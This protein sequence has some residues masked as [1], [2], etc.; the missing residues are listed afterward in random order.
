MKLKNALTRDGARRLI[1]EG[2]LALSQ[3]EA[4]GMR[5]DTDQLQEQTEKIDRRIEKGKA[6]LQRSKMHGRMKRRFREF[7]LTSRT[8]LGKFLFDVEGIDHPTGEKTKG[9]DW[10]CDESVLSKIN[11]PYVKNFNRL[12]KLLKMR[13]VYLEGIHRQT[14]DGFIHPFFHLAFARTHRGTSQDPNFQN[15]PIRDPEMGKIIRSCFIPRDDHQIVEI[16]YSAIEVRVAACYH[17]DPKMLRYINDPSTDMH[18]D[19]AAD[20]FKCDPSQVSKTMRYCGKNMFVFPQFYGSFWR[21]CAENLW[22]AIDSMSLTLEDGTSLKKHLR[23][24]GIKEL[25]ESVS[26][27]DDRRGRIRQSGRAKRNGSGKGRIEAS[28]GFY[29]H[30]SEVEKVLWEKRFRVY[31]QWKKDWFA[32]YEACG[33]FDT[34][35]GF[36]IEGVFKRNDVINYPV[37]GSAFHCLLWSLTQLNKWL[38]K[39]KMKTKIVGQIHDSIVADVHKDELEDYLVMAKEVMT[40]LLP[41]AWRWISVPLEVE[42]EVT[43][44]DGSW[45]DKKE[46]PL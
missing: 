41:K 3:V 19:S 46:V 21:D 44:L 39:N 24:Q 7:N 37:Q 30:I 33:G 1:H 26:H 25:G 15:M 10:K 45:F 28:S 42:A 11:L 13:T 4:N 34:F 29:K 2:T 12:Q 9:G 20:C 18:R 8:Q 32:A 38:K 14:V 23:S 17:N 6:A 40:R 5:V 22:E 36:R 43:P 16:D 31:N 27:Y 35:T